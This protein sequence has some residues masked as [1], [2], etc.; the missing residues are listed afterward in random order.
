MSTLFKKGLGLFLENKLLFLVLVLAA[1]LRLI[2]LSDFPPAVNWDEVSHGYNAYSILK[3]GADEWGQALP[4]VNFRAYGDYPLP[5]NLYMTIPSILV[6]GLNEFAIRF[7]H[8][9]LG[10][11]TTVAT[12]FLAMGL[13]KRRELALLSSFLVAIEPWT[14]FTSRVVLQQNLSIFLLTAS[15][16]AFFNRDKK[17][18]LLP[19]SLAFLFL[20]LFSYHSTRIFSPLILVATL[21]IYRGE[22]KNLIKRESFIPIVS[23][24]ALIAFFV[25]AGA[26]LL[27]PSA[28]ARAKWLFII[29]EGAI[30][31]IEEG[32]LSSSLPQP[33][34]KLIYNRPTY[35]IYHFSRNYLEYLSPQF[36]FLSGGTQFQYSLPGKGLSYLINLPF[37]YLGIY[38]LLKKSFKGDKDYL[39][40]LAWLALSPIAGSI[41]SEHFAVTRASVMLPLPQI[42]AAIGLFFVYDLITK[43]G[44]PATKFIFFTLYFVGIFFLAKSYLTNYFT[45][46]PEE[47]SWSWQY[48][49][50]QAVDYARDN[51]QK[52]DKIIITKK[53]GEP[54]EFFLFFWPWDPAKYKADPNLIRFHQSDWYWV[55]RFDKFYFVNDWQI[56]PGPNDDFTLESGEA[57]SCKTP[58]T[59]CL[60]IT[61]PGNYRVG[62]NKLETINFLDGKPAFEI[63]EN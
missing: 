53:Y 57:V 16:A 45:L 44:N 2:N 43:K 29:N 3:T 19:L 15:A 14:L 30:A 56:T 62:W 24:S 10:V 36:L 34:P 38:I 1:A 28:R 39:L 42:L 60:L 63:L 48:G 51:Y 5:L 31:S 7:P 11:L 54:H 8:A 37:F 21:V 17:K 13:T 26:I 47:Y 55:D 41:T 58:E 32:R 59:K 20:S 4:V 40:L 23:I 46:Y 12:Y 18:Y 49:Y 50:R 52:Y 27:E 22:F 61:S 9:V 25:L 6:F 33:L 35:L